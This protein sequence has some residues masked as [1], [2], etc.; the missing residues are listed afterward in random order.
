M[1]L[2]RYIEATFGGSTP[3]QQ[4]AQLALVSPAEIKAAHARARE[5]G[6]AHPPKDRFTCA[7]VVK[8]AELAA[9]LGCDRR[10]AWLLLQKEREA[11]L[12]YIHQKRPQAAPEKPGER[13]LAILVP[14]GEGAHDAPALPGG[15]D[16]P[17]L[18][19]IEDLRPDGD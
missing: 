14:D 6:I 7:M 19:L 1:D 15:D 5:L 9:A 10:D 17:I 18:D 16:D 12:P 8:A 2:G 13:A 11:L 3:G 4:A